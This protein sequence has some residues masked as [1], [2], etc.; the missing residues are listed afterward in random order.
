MLTV[1]DSLVRD[2]V[3]PEEAE[4]EVRAAFLALASGSADN[5]VRHR[6]R[7]PG[8]SLHTLTASCANLG[9]SACKCYA[10]TKQGVQ[11]LVLLFEN[12]TGKLVAQI[13]SNNLGQLRTAAAS[14]VAAKQLLAPP[15]QSA[16][17]LAIIG[18]GF[19]AAGQLRAFVHAFVPQSVAV[20]SRDAA[21]LKTFCS[22]SEQA[23]NCR[24]EPSV[25]VR[26]AC[27]GVSI[28]VTATT[29]A[30]PVLET[31]DLDQPQ[32]ICAVGSNAL[33]RK[34][35]AP[36]LVTGAKVIVVDDLET[37][38]TEGGN[39]LTPLE[40]GKLNW[41]QLLELGDLIAA[42]TPSPVDQGGYALF[43]S[44]GLAVQDLYLANLIFRKA[45][46]AG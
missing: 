10:A 14:V 3:T 42:K 22:R 44:H 30:T 2:L 35:L 17:R 19:Q 5:V 13:D 40:N 23:L 28:I 15:P 7:A 37:A 11:G 38:K 4:Q 6:S 16:L 20:Y 41:K 39:F 27:R 33:S 26:A 25:S 32:L 8:I 18:T 29:S 31:A 12:A 45:L 9:M 21:R 1:A 24:I 46:A 34:E 43:C 36:Q